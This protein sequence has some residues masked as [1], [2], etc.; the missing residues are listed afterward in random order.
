VPLCLEELEQALTCLADEVVPEVGLTGNSMP[1]ISTTTPSSS[2]I[3]RL[4]ARRTRRPLALLEPRGRSL[5]CPP[6]QPAFRR[7][8]RSLYSVAQNRPG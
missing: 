5:W 6:A 1:M 7:D 4:P 2:M 8:P 3:S